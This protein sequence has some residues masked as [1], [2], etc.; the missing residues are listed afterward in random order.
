MERFIAYFDYLGF[1]QFIENND[2]VYQRR[3][4]NNIFR[5][6]ERALGQGKF[7]FSSNGGAISDLSN[8]KINCINFSDTVVFW[9]NDNSEESLHEILSVSY[10][11]NLEDI[12][13]FFPARGALV[14]GEIEYIDF[15]Q[16]NEGGGLYNINSVFGKGLVK[17]HEK[18]DKQ[19]WAGT[20]IDES[21]IDIVNIRGF[22]QEVFIKP[23]AKRYNVPLK[24]KN[25]IEFQ[26][27][28]VMCITQENLD[29]ESFNNLSKNIRDNF[30]KH[31]K[32]INTDDI[33][34]KIQN[35]I[36]FLASFKKL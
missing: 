12:T 23:F 10:R 29:E 18:A 34:E 15:N 30:A 8:S 1:K 4:I 3:I 2:L 14:Y 5:D 16:N 22:S 21:I 20:I 11:F 24:T 25:G 13:I 28:F 27:E 33:R 6:I 35:T 32:L 7:K 19:H 26:E 31:N 17:A 9:T 36:N